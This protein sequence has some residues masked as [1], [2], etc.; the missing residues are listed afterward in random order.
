MLAIYGG[1]ALTIDFPK[2]AIGIQSDEATYY[3]MGYSLAKDGDLEYRREDLVRV[4]R[5]FS[6][7]PSGLF[8]KQGRDI[9]EGGLMLR[10]PFVW[11]R[12]QPDPDPSRYYYGKS[13]AYPLA[14]A[15]FV[16][17]FGTNGFLVLHARAARARRLVQLPVPARAHER[18]DVGGAGRR[19]RDGVG[20]AG[21][22]R[23]DHARALQL[24]PRPAGVLLLAL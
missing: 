2:A 10:P 14:A 5:E 9:V 18:H 4:W 1:L 21:V 22:F 7:G 13:F 6:G 12:T 3:M 11:T 20:R 8:L 17:V 15:P 16:R 19:V 24:F 23:L